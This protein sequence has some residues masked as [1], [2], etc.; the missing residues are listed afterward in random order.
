MYLISVEGFNAMKYSVY[1]HTHEG[2]MIYFILPFFFHPLIC[3]FN[4]I[5]LRDVAQLG[6]NHVSTNMP[7]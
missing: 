1:A 4:R 5:I 6:L 2:Y 3:D 7:N